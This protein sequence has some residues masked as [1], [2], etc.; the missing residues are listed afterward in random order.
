V[1]GVEKFKLKNIVVLLRVVST[2]SNWKIARIT[3]IYKEGSSDDQSNYRSIFILLV[4][5]RLFEKLIYNELYR[6]LDRYKSIY[7]HQSGFKSIHSVVACLLSNTN[8]CYLNVDD[9]KIQ[10]WF[11]W[12]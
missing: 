2:S 5:S 6:Y 8:R 4:L 1:L 11:L 12:T 10:A 3:P 9:K 7:K